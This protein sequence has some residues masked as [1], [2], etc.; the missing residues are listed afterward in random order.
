LIEPD[1]EYTRAFRNRVLLTSR[2]ISR[3]IMQS[4]ISAGELDAP[5]DIEAVL[6]MVYGPIF[7]R[8]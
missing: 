8:C 5:A 3:E 7:Y 1:S 2:E 6:D 4:A